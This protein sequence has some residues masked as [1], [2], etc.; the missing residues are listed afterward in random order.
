MS[1]VRSRSWALCVGLV[2]LG[3][4]AGCTSGSAEPRGPYW[5]EGVTPEAVAQ[6]LQI[7]LPTK[8]TEAKAAHKRDHDDLIL[9]SFAVPTDEADGFLA[10]LGSEEPVRPGTPFGGQTGLF[11]R[12]GLPE[13][14]SAPGVR[15]AQVCAP[16]MK[17]DLDFLQ[18]AVT[19]VDE[20]NTRVYFRAFD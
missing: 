8:A 16:C 5:V 14:V 18:L 13:P 15:E 12:L 4:V 7:E 20:K 9:L 11:A 19:Q 3:L 2:L 10:R 6:R 1:G 17:R